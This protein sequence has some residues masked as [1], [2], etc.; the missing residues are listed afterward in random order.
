[1]TLRQ[2]RILYL[3]KKWNRSE[4][5]KKDEAELKKDRRAREISA[6]VKYL[7]ENEKRMSST[8]GMTEEI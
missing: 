8:S 3:R 2:P 4:T 1:M 5:S 7:G 6:F